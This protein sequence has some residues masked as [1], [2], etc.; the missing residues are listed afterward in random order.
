MT[1]RI[2]ESVKKVLGIAPEYLVFDQDIVMHINSAF[3]VLHQL[4]VGPDEPF[5]I[6]DETA[7]WSEFLGTERGVNS[8]KSYV[9]LRVRLLFDPPAT[10]FALG[11]MEKQ[12][13][14]LGWRISTYMEGVR[15]PYV[16]PVVETEEEVVW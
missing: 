16:E 1:D 8:V 14:E 6:E 5:I 11:A 4:G 2:L 10:S 13:E 7:T 12:I 15:H 3:S 9:Y